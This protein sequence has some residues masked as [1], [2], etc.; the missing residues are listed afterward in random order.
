MRGET[1]TPPHSFQFFTSFFNQRFLLRTSLPLTHVSVYIDT[2]IIITWNLYGAFQDPKDALMTPL[3]YRRTHWDSWWQ[4]G[5]LRV[6]QMGVLC[7][8]WLLILPWQGPP[9]SCT[10]LSFIWYTEVCSFSLSGLHWASRP[11]SIT[12]VNTGADRC[13]H[14]VQTVEAEA[15][16][17]GSTITTSLIKNSSKMFVWQYTYNLSVEMC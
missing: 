9:H 17:S 8:C 14:A 2:L 5:T 4:W 16:T 1:S 11:P 7:V 13:M 12:W 6:Q 15:H 10:L 3:P